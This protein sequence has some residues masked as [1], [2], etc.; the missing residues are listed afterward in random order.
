MHAKLHFV[1]IHLKI[2]N[3]HDTIKFLSLIYVLQ[4]LLLYNPTKPKWANLITLLKD[5]QVVTINIVLINFNIINVNLFYL[6][7]HIFTCYDIIGRRNCTVVMTLDAKP[8]L[9]LDFYE[10]YPTE[11]KDYYKLSGI[12]LPDVQLQKSKSTT[13]IFKVDAF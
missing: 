2:H 8:I 7:R 11:V 1:Q 3:L 13:Y 6:K 9:K 10:P 12:L 4:S 5:H